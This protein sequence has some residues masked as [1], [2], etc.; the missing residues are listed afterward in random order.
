MNKH[1]LL[2]LGVFFC[3]ILTI[4]AQVN[5]TANQQVTPYTGGFHVGV[6]N[7]YYP[8]QINEGL[9]ELAGGTRN[10]NKPGAGAKAMR[11]GF[12]EELAE[13]FGYD[14]LINLFEHYKN[15]GM[16]DH[17]MIVQGPISWHR[18]SAIYCGQAN[19]VLF[20]NVYEPI[21]DGG[22]NGTPYNDNNFFAAHMYK[23]ATI[24]KPYIKFWEVWNEPGFDNTG[25]IGWLPPGQPNNWWENNPNPCDYI[26]KAP[27]QHYIRH[28]RVAYEVIKTVDPNAYVTCSGVGYP[29]FLDA[30]LRQTDNPNGGAVT[31]AYPLK[32]GAYFDAVGFHSYPHFDGTV[33][34]WDNNCQC[35]V[36]ARHSDAA[37]DGTVTRTKKA[38]DDVLAVH[39]YGSTYPQKVWTITEGNIPAKSFTWG[40][41]QLLGGIEV[42]RNFTIKNMVALIKAGFAQ[43]DQYQIFNTATNAAA[44]EPFQQMGLYDVPA[45]VGATPVRTEQGIAQYTG[46]RHLSGTTYD[47]TK[48][49]AMNLPAN[50]GGGAFK[51]PNGKYVYA[52][53]A[54]TTIDQSESAS[55]TY[56]FHAG[57]GFPTM[58]K[59]TW[60]YQSSSI[61]STNVALT[62][63]P[64]FMN[65]DPAWAAPQTAFTGPTADLSLVMN[66]PPTIAPGQNGIFSLTV[67][68]N[69][70]TAATNVKITNF[71]EFSK[72]YLTDRVAY[73]SHVAPA[74]TTHDYLNGLWTIPN[75]P[76]NSSLTLQV[77]VKPRTNA[78]YNAFAQIGASDQYDNDSQVL[79]GQVIKIPF[80]DDEASFT[81][82]D[83]GFLNTK[84]DLVVEAIIKP[85]S[86]V[87]GGNLSTRFMIRNNGRV[88]TNGAAMKIYL[89]SD[90][91]YSVNDLLLTTQT[92]PAFPPYGYQTYD[93]RTIAI[94]NSPTAGN[95]FLIYKTDSENQVDEFEEG[96]ANDFIRPITLTGGGTGGSKP[97][98]QVTSVNA[99][100]SILANGQKSVNMTV[101]FKNNGPAAISQAA[102][103]DLNGYFST[104]ATLS[105]DDYSTVLSTFPGNLAVGASLTYT[106]S[107][108]YNTANIPFQNGFFI[109]KIDNNNNVDEVNEINNTLSTAISFGT[110]PPT[111]CT[112][113][114]L[115]N[116]GFESGFSGWDNPNGA[117][118]VSDVQAGTGA[119]SL[120]TSAGS[121]RVY[122]TKTAT[123][124]TSYTFKAFAKKTGAATG[125][126]FVK[127]MTSGFSPIQSD[128]Q[129]IGNSTYT[130]VS[131]TKIAPTGTAFIEV[132]FIKNDGSGCILADE[133]CL[134]TGSVGN[135]CSPDVTAPTI[136]GCPTNINLTTTST[137][138]IATWSAPTATDACTATTLTSNFNSGASFPIGATTVT[139]TARDAANNSAVCNFIVTVSTQVTGGGCTGNLLLNNGFESGFA[140]WDNPNGATLVADAQAG[141]QAMSLCTANGASR[142]YQ[143]RAATAGT[144]YTFKAFCKKTGTAPTN[145][146]IKFMTSGY[147]PISTDFQ[148]ANST[149]YAEVSITKTAP[150]NTAFIE[151]GFIKDNGT[152]CFF[153]DETCL[154]TGGGNS[155]PCVPDVTAPA[156]AG[157]PA[158][159]SLNTTTTNAIATWIAPTATDACGATTLTSNFNSGASFPIG[160]TTVTY[161]ARDAA[162][163]SA[164]CNF[165]VSVTQ[166]GGGGNGADLQ[167]TMTADKTQVAQWSNVTYTIIAKNNGTAAINSANIKVGGCTT[168]GFQTFSNTFGLVF[169]GA[170]GQPTSGSFNAV[171][172]DW[173]L[174][175]LAAGQMSTLTVALFSTGTNE[176]KVVAFASAQSPTDPDSQPS[177]NLAN[178]TAAQDDEAVW[179]V[180]VGQLSLAAADREAQDLITFEKLSNLEQITDY[181]LF[182]NPANEVFYLKT[183]DY[184][185][186]KVT[187]LNQMGVVEKIQEFPLALSETDKFREFSL[188]GMANG[189]YFVKIETAGQR[190]VVKKLVVSRMY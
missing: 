117:T 7:G 29:A 75:L 57:F 183:P 112:G 122:Q 67:S 34:Y 135:P 41:D 94:P 149:T 77:T 59:R 128:F 187:I 148:N 173:S 164:I 137:N 139:Y 159:I 9:G 36:N 97:D 38:Y 19:S 142:L 20:R 39:G 169:A 115:T 152:G 45:F 31:A 5:Y 89:S 80:E 74:G 25:S 84:A 136:S 188:D 167:I 181:H 85:A 182:P 146:F 72:E 79:N 156:I 107:P 175:N 108:A 113:N 13:L 88:G 162:N 62:G 50:V 90:N 71:L 40:P 52:I 70:S 35:M 98:L 65:E 21:W 177:A 60:D 154:T 16:N 11:V 130:E 15:M 47:A 124:G 53:W 129:N 10:L 109:V 110:T 103:Y 179:T 114:L 118:I 104:D 100:G 78:P 1:S 12:N 27:V 92:V 28:L 54:K 121:N 189:V 49:A 83:N 165:T 24:Y 82:N 171:S 160:S 155:N 123:A 184:Q 37:A 63:A 44:G 161:T 95:Y 3:A 125:S 143:T 56:S 6:N 102:G 58:T 91:V 93:V 30:I 144:A 2:I 116:S 33:R 147:A 66:A 17:V 8:N 99:T 141:T 186:V 86:V 96:A 76:A 134:T 48:T 106:A 69:S 32:G 111:G 81:I 64:I 18:D 133:S 174:T 14:I 168:A 170:P 132:G 43:Y 138:A 153:A 119:M 163:N 157:C 180:N 22:A 120:C 176:R 190:T 185:A 46:S 150:A 87:I 55:A 145:I 178:C 73:V 68:N 151:V 166:G 4:N 172:Q 105:V 51:I 126:I 158:N 140:N 23:M 127:F 101:I 42:Q 61:S 26:L 131:L